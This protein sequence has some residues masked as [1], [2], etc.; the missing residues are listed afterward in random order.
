MVGFGCWPSHPLRHGKQ[1]IQ[2]DRKRELKVNKN[3]K[4]L[5]QGFTLLTSHEVTEALRTP[6]AKLK[7]MPSFPAEIKI[8]TGRFFLLCEL[9]DFINSEKQNKADK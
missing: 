2:H 4:T 5:G 6:M 1:I 9:E 7:K 3:G 8:G